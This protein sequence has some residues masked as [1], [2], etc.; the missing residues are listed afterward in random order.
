MGPKQEGRKTRLQGRG[1]ERGAWL[2]SL[3]MWRNPRKQTEHRVGRHSLQWVS[4][5]LSNLPLG[6]HT[7]CLPDRTCH[8]PCLP[9]SAS[10]HIGWEQSPSLQTARVPSDCEEPILHPVSLGQPCAHGRLARGS[11]RLSFPRTPWKIPLS[12][13]PASPS[14]PTGPPFS[15]G[16]FGSQKD[17]FFQSSSLDWLQA[18]GSLWPKLKPGTIP[19]QVSSQCPVYLYSTNDWNH[20]APDKWDLFI[21]SIS[22]WAI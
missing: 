9:S 15:P 8:S 20:Y 18:S 4:A 7:Q 19:E 13:S 22:R 21:N 6:W 5:A 16:G 14:R 10:H 2:S 1:T 12:H 17:C 3:C 11:P